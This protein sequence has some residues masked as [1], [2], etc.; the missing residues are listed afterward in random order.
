MISENKII[1]YLE[2]RLSPEELAAFESALKSSVELRAQLKEYRS[3]FKD[4]DQL[5]EYQ[6]SKKLSHNFYEM[7]E[8]EKANQY[9]REKGPLKSSRIIIGIAAGF[10]LLLSGFWLGNNMNNNQQIQLSQIE[11]DLQETQVI[12]LQLLQKESASQRIKAVNYSYEVERSNQKIIDA[13]IRTMNFDPNTNVRLHAAEALA[14]FGQETKVRDAFL[15]ALA[16]QDNPEMQIKAINILVHLNERRAV[17][18]MLKLLE[19]EDIIDAVKQ[20]AQTGLE[21]LL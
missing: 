14:R 7:L 16:S 13:L 5:P 6:P 9:S 21:I 2:G 12:M 11:K 1:D 10:A 3:F 19:K 8:A 4:I 15:V 20:Q 17:G 18:E